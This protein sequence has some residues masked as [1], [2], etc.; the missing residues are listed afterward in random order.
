MPDVVFI[1]E[2]APNQQHAGGKGVKDIE[3]VLQ[4]NYSQLT[5]LYTMPGRREIFT[6]IKTFW[7]NFWS[8]RHTVQTC[9]NKTIII[10]YPHYNYGLS[11]KKQLHRILKTNKVILLVHDV[12]SIRF[13]T[14]IEEEVNLLNQASVVVLH[15]QYMTDYLKAHGLTTKVV[16]VDIFDYLVPKIPERNNYRLGKQI[17][18]A[19]NLGKSKFIKQL[20]DESLGVSLNLYGPNL[21]LKIKNKVHW[22]GSYLP[23]EIPFK[24][25]GSFG[26]VWDGDSIDGCKGLIGDY[27]KVNYPHKLSLYLAAGIPVITWKQAAIAKIV[28]KYN[29]GF[30]VDSLKEVSDYIDS[31]SQE[32][33]RKYL[34]NVAE[35]QKKVISG[36]FTKE[37]FNRAVEL[38]N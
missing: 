9:K 31:L 1:S 18:F 20:A 33:Y 32:D 4:D 19:G 3:S 14:G 6:Y 5:I 16:N 2:K 13:N 37:A 7:H 38:I 17:V 22:L 25:K 26:L 12:D 8:F 27:L 28:E 29:I 11:L 23:E 35:L 15:N 24:I 30:I 36:N 21:D 34:N 10:Q